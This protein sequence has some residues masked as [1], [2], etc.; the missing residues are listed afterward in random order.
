MWRYGNLKDRVVWVGG[1]TDRE[2]NERDTFMGG[3]N[4]ELGGNFPVRNP[5]E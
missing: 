2:N 3:G 4:L 5:Q 1:S